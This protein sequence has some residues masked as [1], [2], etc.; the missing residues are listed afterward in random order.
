[1]LKILLFFLFPLTC[2]AA[3]FKSDAEKQ[4]NKLKVKLLSEVRS[5]MAEGGALKAMEFC[6]E[7]ALGL[8]EEAAQKGYSLG[9]TSL[10]YRNPQNAPE[11]WMQEFL[12]QADSST[13][14]K[15][16][17][18]RVVQN[19]K[20]EDVYLSPLYTAAACLQCHGSPAGALK[21][22]LDELYPEDK[23]TGY[24]PGQFR[25]FVWVKKK[26]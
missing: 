10:K 11:K 20:G 4:A 13:A 3:D 22:K 16:Y 2:A 9:R 21:D 23:A 15:P 12:R 25:G 24:R 26:D 14:K 19:S 1:M 17:A 7:K 8:T 18:A 6:H 5:K